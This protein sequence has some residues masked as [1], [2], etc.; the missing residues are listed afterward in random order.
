MFFKLH[1]EMKIGYKCLTDADLGKKE[2]SH[3]THIG[4][5]DDILTFLPNNNCVIDDAMVIYNDDIEFLNVSFDRIENP[6]HTF[7]SPKIKTGGVNT[8]S[9]VSFIRDRA[10]EYEIDVNWYLFWF[11]LESKQ[12]VFFLFNNESRTFE[13]ISNLGIELRVGVK[14]RIDPSHEAFLPLLNYLERIVNKTGENFAIE[15]EVAAQTNE[16]VSNKYKNAY[17]SYDIEKAK[18]MFS[19]I[20]R[21]GEKL[22]DN[23]FSKQLEEGSIQY[24]EWKNREKES[25]LP[26]DFSVQNLDGEIVY[27]DVKNTN[28]SFEQKMIFSSQEIKFIYNCP[29]KYHIYRVYNNEGRI[30]LKICNNAKELCTQLYNKIVSFEGTMIDIANVESVKIS[31]LPTHELLNFGNE[32]E[33]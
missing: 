4:L 24:Y 18:E 14:K 25:G 11:G 20:G 23:Y 13:E 33:L 15:L 2:T 12:P 32:I 17:R 6:D 19:F 9:V 16:E 29:N 5:F 21:E 1:N 27:L 26:Y 8:V 28:Y 10:K 7:R 31:M 3:Q 30:C 22:I